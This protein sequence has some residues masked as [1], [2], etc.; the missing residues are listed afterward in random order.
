MTH[1]VKV[2]LSR[3]RAS[4][5]AIASDGE[6]ESERREKRGCRSPLLSCD[7][8]DCSIMKLLDFTVLIV[9]ARER[10]GERR[11]EVN[12]YLSQSIIALL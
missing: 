8:N 3:A 6:S 1:Q 2:L 5:R 10:S 9:I 4:E 12:H 7:D 11:V